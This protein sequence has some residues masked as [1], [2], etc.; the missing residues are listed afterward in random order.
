MLFTSGSSG[1]PKAVVHS[2]FSLWSSAR[3]SNE[4]L[5]FSSGHRWLQSLFLW[6]IG[7]LMI[8]IRALYGG[9]SIVEKDPLMTMG[10]QVDHD[11]ITHLSVVATQLYDLLQGDHLFVFIDG[12]IGWW[13][14]D[15]ILRLVDRS[16]RRSI[17][18]HTTYGMTE[19]GSQLTTTPPQSSLELLRSAGKPLGDWQI[20]ISSNQE[21]QVQ[22]SPCFSAIGTDL[23][24]K[25][26]GMLMDG[27]VQTIAVL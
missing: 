12:R 15:S 16:H 5:P 6:H 3:F 10:S 22:G 18:I 21:I 23:P 20:R 9:S 11:Q 7:G 26:A 25:I 24:L 19:L 8:P 14:N 13:W 2:F 1:A 17:P 4:N 27:L